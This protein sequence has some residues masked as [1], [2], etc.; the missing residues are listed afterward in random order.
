MVPPTDVETS[1]HGA[2]VTVRPVQGDS[3]AGGMARA[4][5]RN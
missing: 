2:S 3:H 4:A 1:Y 5:R